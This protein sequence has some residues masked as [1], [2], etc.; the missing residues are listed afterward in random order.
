LRLSL[1]GDSGHRLAIEVDNACNPTCIGIYDTKE[2][3]QA[4][5]DAVKAIYDLYGITP[6]T[7]VEDWKTQKATLLHKAEELLLTDLP[8][9]PVLFNEHAVAY[10]DEMITDMT[11]DYYV[12]NLFTEAMLENYLD[13]TYI[14][15]QG[16]LTSIFAA[17]P[18]I[19]WEKAGYDYSPQE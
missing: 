2:E 16:K 10:S 9:I 19:E 7:K 13:Y 3:F 8:I 1:L 12:P 18:E 6:T 17:F 15:K 5:Y 4:T 14:N 11:A